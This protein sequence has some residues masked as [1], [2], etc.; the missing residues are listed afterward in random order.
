M[1]SDWQL[2]LLKQHHED[3]EVVRREDDVE[4]KAEEVSARCFP[5]LHRSHEQPRR[6]AERAEHQKPASCVAELECGEAA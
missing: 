4:S 3:D 1:I 2:R 6:H 5:A